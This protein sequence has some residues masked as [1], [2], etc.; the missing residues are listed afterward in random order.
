MPGATEP[1]RVSRFEADLLT[2]LQGFLGHLPRSQVLPLLA[3]AAERPPCLSRNCVEL[4]KDALAKGTTLILAGDAWTRQRFLR[5]GQIVSGRLWERSPP[6]ELGLEFSPLSLDFLIWA[7]SASVDSPDTVWKMPAR[8]KP[9]LG[10]RWLLALAYETVRNLPYSLRWIAQPPWRTDGL[11]QLLFCEDHAQAGVTDKPDFEPWLM[12]AG[13]AIL[14]AS[15]R[16]LAD[17]WVEMELAKARATDI[18]SLR[19]TAAAQARVLESF[20]SAIDSAGRRDLARF[21]F[22]ALKRLLRPGVTL[23]QWTG[24]L[25][26]AGARLADRQGAYRDALAVLAQFQ[27][28]EA[29]QHEARGVGYFD[30]NYPA[31]QL[32]KSDWESYNGDRLAAGARALLDQTLWV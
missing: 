20:F 7:T 10:D 5:A 30:E 24:E 13:T 12:P 18:E 21:L 9:S 29:W 15:Q 25:R 31:A 1:R 16:R 2:I 17:R 26:L 32:W 23:Q 19:A 22:P 11:C 3:Q 27:R 28:L 6:V 4:V 8:R 14:E